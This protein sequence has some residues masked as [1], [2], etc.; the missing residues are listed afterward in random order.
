MAKHGKED[1]AF[2][3]NRSKLMKVL[4]YDNGCNWV[5]MTVAAAALGGVPALQAVLRTERSAV[6]YKRRLEWTE[7]KIR[8]LTNGERYECKEEAAEREKVERKTVVKAAEREEVKPQNVVKKHERE[9]AKCKDDRLHV[10]ARAKAKPRGALA[11]PSAYGVVK[12][13]SDMVE[14]KVE[15]ESESEDDCVIL[16]SPLKRR[17][18]RK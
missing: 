9:E 12:N 3:R 18:G 5:S 2:Y 14:V 1:Q 15:M 8:A 13:E 17:R 4:R 10:G 6:G 7:T 11:L 16:A